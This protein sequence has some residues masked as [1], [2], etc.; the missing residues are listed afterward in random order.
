MPRP[1]KG[2]IRVKQLAGEN[3]DGTAREAYYAIVRDRERLIGQSPDWNP[4]RAE[5]ELKRRILPQAQLGMPWWEKYGSLALAAAAASDQSLTFHEAAQDLVEK[6]VSD[7]GGRMVDG[8]PVIPDD[9]KNTW[10]AFSSPLF[11]HVLPFM[12][13]YDDERTLPRLLEDVTPVL[14]D[15]FKAEKIRERDALEELAETIAE[16]DDATLRDDEALQHQLGP[17]DFRLLVTYGQRSKNGRRSLSSRGLFEGEINR[18]LQ[19]VRDVV[20]LA[21]RNYKLGLNDPTEEKFYTPRTIRELREAKRGTYLEPAQLQAIFDAADE[22]DKGAKR[23]STKR[24]PIVR[25]LA[26]AG[27]RVSEVAGIRPSHISLDANHIFIPDSK[28]NA[29]KRNIWM[30]KL[31]RDAVVEAMLDGEDYLFATDTGRQ[32]DRHNIRVRV[33]APV[34]ERAQELLLERGERALPGTVLRH[35]KGRTEIVR[36]PIPKGDPQV[37]IVPGRVTPHLFRRT[38]LSYLAW[39]GPG[40][41]STGPQRTQRFA[42]SQAG[43]RSAALT[44]EIFQQDMPHVLDPRVPKWLQDPKLPSA[45]APRRRTKTTSSEAPTRSAPAATK[46]RGSGASGKRQHEA[47]RS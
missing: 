36:G 10:N 11:K 19:R 13:Y 46:R 21:N 30:H 32:R 43:H 44:L 5:E 40:T 1:L 23:Y 18:C 15:D 31:V 16:L 17:E 7:L 37:E 20:K 8:K 22:L 3:P 26:L 28:T 45:K 6:K 42:M 39:A 41:K 29:G 35:S 9:K 24:G 33:L 34:I 12:A 27:P 47:T 14:I 2:R 4:T 38:Y 25:V